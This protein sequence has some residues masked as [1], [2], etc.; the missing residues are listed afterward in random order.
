MKKNLK[1]GRKR[2]PQKPSEV[3]ITQAMLYEVRNELKADIRSLSHRFDSIDSK[4]ESIDKRF[5]SMDHKIDSKT[6]EMMSAI[7][8]I[9]LLV[10]EQNAKNDIVLEGLSNLFHRQERLEGELGEFRKDFSGLK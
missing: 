4:F 7:H 2:S 1:S 10:E 8:R 9:G 5:V 6:E 3:P